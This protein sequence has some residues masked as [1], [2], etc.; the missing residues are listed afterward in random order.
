MAPNLS[1]DDLAALEDVLSV[2]GRDVD[3]DVIDGDGWRECSDGVMRW[4]LN[5]ASGVMFRCQGADGVV[6][7]LLEQRS[8]EVDAGGTWGVPGGAIRTGEDTLKGALRE[9]AEEMGMAQAPVG[10]EVGSYAFEPAGDWSYTTHVV[11][12]DEQFDANL[13]DDPEGFVSW[14]NEEW[15]W[16]TQEE[17]RELNLHPGFAASLDHVLAAAGDL[18]PP[19]PKL[20]M[21]GAPDAP[22]PAPTVAPTHSV[23]IN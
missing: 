20:P 1:P 8:A 13:A 23:P 22:M 12:V 5:G 4:G 2:E 21:I 11:D 15:R 19:R 9:A 7:Y 14:E 10:R 18:S 3:F 17:M 6:R 16:V